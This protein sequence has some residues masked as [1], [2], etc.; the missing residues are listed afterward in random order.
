[1]AEITIIAADGFGLATIVPI[2]P[3]PQV[4]AALS[5][6]ASLLAIGPQQVPAHADCGGPDWAEAVGTRLAGLAHVVDQSSAYALFA[7]AG[8]GAWRLLQKGLP[9]DL[10]PEHFPVGGVVVSAIAQIGVIARHRAPDRF[11]LL[12]ARSLAGHFRHWLD[13]AA[14]TVAGAAPHGEPTGTASS[15]K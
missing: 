6:M 14:P 4:A 10:S 11:D 2:A 15:A 7:L 1:V 5:G 12:V 13:T 9:V 3:L 8:P